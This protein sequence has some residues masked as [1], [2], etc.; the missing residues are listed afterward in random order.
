MSW[1]ARVEEV[2]GHRR[3]GCDS[4]LREEL[5]SLIV[6]H[7]ECNASCRIG[8]KGDTFVEAGERLG[9]EVQVDAVIEC[10]LLAEGD[11]GAHAAEHGTDHLRQCNDVGSAH[12]A[13][14][15]VRSALIPAR[16][17]DID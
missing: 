17:A 9:R 14:D 1:I 16:M 5:P 10:Q 2:E 8:H 15:D 4:T 11:G 12:F 3:P 6:D 13:A 7:S